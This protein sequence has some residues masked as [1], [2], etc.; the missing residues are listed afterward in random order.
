M[1]WGFGVEVVLIGGC[2]QMMMGISA[3][4]LSFEKELRRGCGWTGSGRDRGNVHD[5]RRGL[6]RLVFALDF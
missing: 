2:V 4:L 5:F 1:E 6:R 3:L